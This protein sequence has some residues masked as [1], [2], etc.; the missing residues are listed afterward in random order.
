[1]KPATEV[2]KTL[3]NLPAE[4]V[5]LG[6]CI[7]DRSRLAQHFSP[8]CQKLIAADDDSPGVPVSDRPSLGRREVFRDLLRM[9]AFRLE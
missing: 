4:Q 7:F 3:P 6:H 1:M 2:L 9:R 5:Q 8:V